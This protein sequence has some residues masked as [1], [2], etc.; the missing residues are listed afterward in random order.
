MADVAPVGRGRGLGLTVVDQ[1]TRSALMQKLQRHDD[2]GLLP[3][4][5]T[6]RQWFDEVATDSDAVE[7][8]GEEISEEEDA[9]AAALERLLALPGKGID[10]DQA[11]S[12]LRR[13]F[14]HAS[15][16]FEASPTLKAAAARR[17]EDVVG[18]A[19]AE[20]GDGELVSFRYWFNNPMIGLHDMLWKLLS[21]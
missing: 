1:E 5:A 7:D 3:T 2:E 6:C 8:E 9:E 13:A 19:G 21:P 16:H 15:A 11:L 10:R 12:L 20:I 4:A 14:E 17:F 18:D